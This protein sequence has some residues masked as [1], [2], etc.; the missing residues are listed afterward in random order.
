MLEAL[1]FLESLPKLLLKV[2]DFF[3]SSVYVAGP[4]PL[5]RLIFPSTSNA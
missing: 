5:V 2:C 4:G 1:G 3:L